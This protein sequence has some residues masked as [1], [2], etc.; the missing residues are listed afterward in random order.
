[1][2]NLNPSRLCL[3]LLILNCFKSESEGALPH[4]NITTEYTTKP[5]PTPRTPKPTR[6]ILNNSRKRP[7]RLKRKMNRASN[8]N[9]T[10][11]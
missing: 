3:M 1:M 6:D 7:K 8:E 9:T 5:T 10:G 4:P 2:K 11:Q